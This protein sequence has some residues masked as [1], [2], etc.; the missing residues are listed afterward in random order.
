MSKCG[1]AKFMLHLQMYYYY[2]TTSQPPPPSLILPFTR[3]A[4]VKQAVTAWLQTCD[5][6]YYS[7]IQVLVPR[8][9]ICLNANND[10]MNV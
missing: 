1:R 10:N 2:Y 8:W 5:D 7:G 4:D 9:N 6:F 3:D